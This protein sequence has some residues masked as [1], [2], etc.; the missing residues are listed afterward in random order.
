MFEDIFDA[1]VTF[2]HDLKWNLEHGGGMALAY[3]IFAGTVFVFLFPIAPDTVL[4]LLFPPFFFLV[5]LICYRIV[6]IFIKP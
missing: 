1:I 3:L 2:F 6:R 5:A 4:E